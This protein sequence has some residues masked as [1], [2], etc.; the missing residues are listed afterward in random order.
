MSLFSRRHTPFAP[1]FIL[2][3]LNSC[4]ER[5]IQHSNK[6]PINQTNNNK[7]MLQVKCVRI[8]LKSSSVLLPDLIN[9]PVL[10]TMLTPINVHDIIFHEMHVLTLNGLF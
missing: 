9:I 7:N 5:K 2:D 1:S 8:I 6:K 10:V 4:R 3:S